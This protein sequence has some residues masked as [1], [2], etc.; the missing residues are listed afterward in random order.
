MFC[1]AEGQLG[2]HVI[3]H[4]LHP[5]AFS[6]HRELR[7]DGAIADDAQRF[8]ANFIRVVSRLEPA[9]PV[10]SGAFGRNAT[11]QQYRLGQHQLGHRA[12]I[13][14]R[15]I[16]YRDTLFPGGVQVYLIST[17]AKAAHGGQLVGVCKHVCRQL[18][19]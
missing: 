13:G 7:A 19:A 1:I 18:R 8:A 10:R 5:Q 16:K 3:K 17:N 4:H 2:D 14:K 9:A 12:G 6:Q 15:G 11:Q